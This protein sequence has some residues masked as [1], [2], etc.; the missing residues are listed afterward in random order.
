MRRWAS[1][2]RNAAFSA[3]EVANFLR[4]RFTDEQRR[5]L[6]VKGKA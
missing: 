2:A 1:R 4:V 3:G 6:A 5:R